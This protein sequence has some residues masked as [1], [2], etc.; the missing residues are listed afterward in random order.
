MSAN[1]ANISICDRAFP[2]L[3]QCCS[4]TL[5][6]DIKPSKQYQSLRQSL[7]NINEIRMRLQFGF[8]PWT[9]EVKLKVEGRE[10]TCSQLK[11][12]NWMHFSQIKAF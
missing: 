12:N 4:K 1:N 2:S 9:V 8:L 3:L 10:G 7:Q 5:D 11:S 6:P